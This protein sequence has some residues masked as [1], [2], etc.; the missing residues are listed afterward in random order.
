M[1][2]LIQMKLKSSNDKVWFTA[3]RGSYLPASRKGLI[4]Y[5]LYVLY[6]VALMVFWNV[7]DRDTWE[8]LTAVIP[9][10]IAAAGLTQYIAAKHS[11][12]R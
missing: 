2:L 1:L 3:V 6:L 4:V 8:L 5:L 9:L 7:R 12:K 11:N 10:S